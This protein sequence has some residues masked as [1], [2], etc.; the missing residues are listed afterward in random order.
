VKKR[1]GF[2]ATFLFAAKKKASVWCW[3]LLIIFQ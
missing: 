3:L 1:G 2:P